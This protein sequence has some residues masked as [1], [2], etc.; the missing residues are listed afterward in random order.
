MHNT[1]IE[2]NDFDL[3]T[4]SG[5]DRIPFLQGQVSCDM[6]ALTPT[7][8]L[9]GAYCNLQGRVI[10]DF[11]VFAH[12]D[13]CRLVFSPGMG[14][15]VKKLL[16]KYIVFSKAEMTLDAGRF[17]RLGLVGDEA[18]PLV[19]SLY[20]EVPG[21]EGDVLNSDGDL[22]IR[23]PGAVPRFEL[24]IDSN[25][26]RSGQ[27]EALRHDTLA[28]NS[29]DWLRQ[30]IAAGIVHVDM[31]RSE[32]FTPQLLNY[33]IAGVINFKK[34]CYTGQEI[35]AR[36]F[37]RG[38]A[39][40]RLFRS[41]VETT[42]LSKEV[43]VVDARDRETGEGILEFCAVADGVFELL[44]ILPTEAANDARSNKSALALSTDP[45]S[46]LEI[47]PLPYRES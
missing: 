12:D 47:L 5:S 38:K 17:E 33:D 30:D 31:Q 2:L 27:I 15:V 7:R 44:V 18:G 39:K 1:L 20:N 28:G 40:K 9:V 43:T 37:Y 34:G 23:L 36:M 8:S 16:D 19:K 24:W 29:D 10:A 25:A 3:L 22:I 41:R 14:S 26:N 6:Q 21:A 45:R 46:H 11:R 42:T 13:C 35:V 4:V 32:Q